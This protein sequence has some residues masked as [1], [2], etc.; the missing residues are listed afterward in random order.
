LAVAATAA[1]V[2]VVVSWAPWRPAPKPASRRL[3]SSIGADA[4]MPINL[5]ASAILSP[6]GTLLVFVAQQGGHS[7]LFARRLDQLQATA[8][9]DTDD[10]FN[11]FFSPDGRFVGFFDGIHLKKVA[12]AGG[13]AMTLGDAT[14]SRGATW[15]EDDTIVF[16]PSSARNSKLLRVSAAG[17]T[18]SVFGTLTEGAMTQRWP[19]ALPGGRDVLYTEHSAAEGFDLANLVVAPLSGGPPKVVLRGGYYGRYV[20]S[21]PR[22]GGGH[23]IYVQQGTLFAVPFNLTRL[24]TSGA[25]AA[26]LEAFATNPTTGG[27]QIAFSMDGTLAYVPGATVAVKRT[28]DWLARDGTTSVLRATPSSWTTPRF[29]PDGQR[30]ALAILTGKQ[31]NIW[32]FDPARETTTQLTFDVSLDLGPAWS[33]DGKHI[34]FSSDRGGSGVYNLYVVNADGSGGV[35]RLTESP[36]SQLNAFWHP[37]G[38]SIVF[39]EARTDTKRD[40]LRLPLKM[41]SER[42]SVAAGSA[43]VVVGTSADEFAPAFSPDGRWMAYESNEIGTNEVFVRPF[44]EAGGKWRVSTAGALYPRWSQT[45]REL[46]FLSPTQNLVLFA[47]YSATSDTFA[48]DAPRV[49]S[50][51]KYQTLPGNNLPYDLHPDGKRLALLA[52]KGQDVVED[53]VVIV[54]SFFDDL[55]RSA[56]AR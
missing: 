41:D 35:T 3:L 38:T 28:I 31:R 42:G 22:P 36:N 32:I 34:V 44:P 37:G 51:T 12:V 54:S 48:A 46:L 6:D 49:W 55:R 39:D 45:S 53:K 8:L 16:S 56:P 43:A 9:P 2:A 24:E 4:S 11:P 13:A 26:V 19:Q 18:P 29:S 7:R 15:A 33:P 23:L 10:A 21:G 40:I 5:G 30:L 25:P 47:R 14:S 52:S 50:P 20:P 1:L 17:G 27:A